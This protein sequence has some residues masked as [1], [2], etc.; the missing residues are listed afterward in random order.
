MQSGGGGGGEFSAALI[1]KIDLAIQNT[2]GQASGRG[3]ARLDSLE[4]RVTESEDTLA[5]LAARKP[6]ATCAAMDVSGALVTDQEHRERFRELDPRRRGYITAAD[7]VAFYRAQSPFA[8]EE[9]DAAVRALLLAMMAPSHA[10]ETDLVT[11]EEFS[12]VAL[13]LA[14]R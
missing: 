1:H 2:V 7:L 4:Q 13:Q 10:M 14:R 11:L 12:A 5:A 6:R 8:A 9:N 3:G